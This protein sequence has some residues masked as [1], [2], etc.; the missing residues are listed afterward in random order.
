MGQDEAVYAQGHAESV[1]R[2]QY[3]RS[4]DNSAAYL[5]PYLRAGLEVLDIGCGP[6]TITVDLA[7]R[8]APG[9]VTGVD[10]AESVLRQARVTASEAEVHNVV[11]SRGDVFALRAGSNT[12]DVTHAHQ[13]LLHL[14]EPVAALREMLRVTRPGGLVAVR[15]T[16]YAAATWWPAD[17][18]LERWL[19]IYRAVARANGAEPDAGR[20]LLAWAYEAGASEVTPSASVWC[21]ATPEER[22]WWG[23]MWA[24]R[25]TDSRIAEQAVEGGHA[26]PEE[27]GEISEAWREWARNPDG[28]FVLLHGEVLCRV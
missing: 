17:S 26:T 10:P 19:E 23:G 25:V 1:V 16:D 9:T 8:V 6:G 27:L 7:R 4:V 14:S 21:H 22:A 3:W 15:D 12:F 24:E 2:S 20:R 13:V 18:R 28:W 5:D 11:F